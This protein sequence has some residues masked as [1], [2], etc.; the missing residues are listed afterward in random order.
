MDQITA[1]PRCDDSSASIKSIETSYY[2]ARYYDPAAGRFLNGDPIGFNGD[3]N[4]Y[5]YAGNSSTNLV[6][7]LGL[8]SGAT[9]KIEYDNMKNN[10]WPMTPNLVP[11][12]LSDCTKK[13]LQPYFPGLNLDGVGLLPRLP[14]FTKFA[15]IDVGAITWDNTISY[16]AGF[17]SGSAG[18]L[19]A[20]GHEITHVQQQ[21]G[22]L[23]SF[24]GSYLGDY[25]KNLLSTGDPA[26]A[27]ENIRAEKDA[28]Q[29]E[30]RILG[31]LLR[32]YGM[33]DPCKAI[34]Q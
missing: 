4:F 16:Q 5:R 34:C 6:D 8:Q 28:N 26:A 2:R 33:N 21:S 3:F 14:G 18:G 9:Y 13:I 31:D 20:L 22:G 27:Y 10:P 32:K 12:H 19:A 24:L 11:R 25:L 30:T 1:R 15:P 29:M 7:P 23:A 17:L